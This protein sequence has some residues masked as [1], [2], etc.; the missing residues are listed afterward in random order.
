MIR[1]AEP[2]EGVGFQGKVKEFYFLGSQERY[3]VE[4]ENG[5]SILVDEHKVDEHKRKEFQERGIN[6]T[7]VFRCPRPP[8]FLEAPL[9]G[10]LLFSLDP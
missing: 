1:F 2:K 10:Y 4:L 9:K 8:P 5:P 6:R 7:P 3:V